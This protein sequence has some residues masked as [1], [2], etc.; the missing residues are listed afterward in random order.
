MTPSSVWMPPG[1]TAAARTPRPRCRWSEGNRE[2][3]VGGFETQFGTNHLGHF[4]LVNR[5]CPLISRRRTPDQT[6]RRPDIA[7]PMW[8]STTPI[9]QSTAY[10]P[11]VAYGRSKTANILFAVF[12]DQRP[13]RAG[14]PCGSRPSGRHPHRTRR[15]MD[16]TNFIR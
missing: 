4:V 16:S 8:T 13:S 1:W 7:S 14:G 10:D 12:F 2:K 15:H 9:F 5:N 3:Y 6:S 11:F